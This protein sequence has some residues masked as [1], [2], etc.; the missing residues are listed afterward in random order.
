[1]MGQLAGLVH[2]DQMGIPTQIPTQILMVM[3][4]EEFLFVPLKRCIYAT[5][6][7]KACSSTYRE[8][9]G[10][11]TTTTNGRKTWGMAGTPFTRILSPKYE[12]AFGK[13]RVTELFSGKPLKSPRLISTTVT[14]TNV[15]LNFEGISAH[16]MQWGQFIAHEFTQLAEAA[17]NTACCAD[18][19]ADTVYGR[20]ATSAQIDSIRDLVKRFRGDIC[21]QIE[22]PLD[23]VYKEPICMNHVRSKSAPEHN[24]VGGPRQQ[25]N[26][27]THVFDASNVYGSSQAEQNRLRDSSGGRL[28]TQTVKG[29]SLPPQDTRG[30]PANKVQSNRCPF[31]GG[32][33]RI[34]TTPNLISAHTAF[35]NKHNQIAK[36]LATQNPQWDNEKLFQET[37]K[38]ISAIQSNIHF[39]EY[40]PI[41]LGSTTMSKYRLSSYAGYDRNTNP[42]ILNELAGAAFRFG[43]STI[44]GFITMV[45]DSGPSQ[46]IDLKDNFFNSDLIYKDGVKQCAKGLST[47]RPWNVDRNFPSQMRDFLFD[48]KLD[49]TSLNINRGRDH[50]FRSYVDYR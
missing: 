32:D 25:M 7:S 39:Y 4:I 48:S 47:D 38:I 49:I 26:A 46:F 43:H 16:T 5:A 35:V 14:T 33:S 3:A 28:K 15:I 21:Q 18:Q 45:K 19:I 41:I 13:R 44:D 8:P 1:M 34:N 37:R 12:D 30:C 23:P 17:P 50:G 2:Q 31:L 27:I 6:N 22:M 42:S 11:C 40:L 9:T 36:G 29:I 20:G 24:C 10:R